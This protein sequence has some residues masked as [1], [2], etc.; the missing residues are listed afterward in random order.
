M[1]LSNEKS[2]GKKKRCKLGH[3]KKKTFMKTEIERYNLNVQLRIIDGNIHVKN[4]ERCHTVAP[5]IK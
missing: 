2:R 1:L 3:K 4:T 5:F